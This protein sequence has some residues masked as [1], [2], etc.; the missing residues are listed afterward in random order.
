VKY[1]NPRL[2][3]CSSMVAGA[4]FDGPSYAE[5]FSA[6]C[7]RCGASKWERTKRGEPYGWRC[8]Y[9]GSAKAPSA[10]IAAI[11]EHLLGFR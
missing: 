11:E 9:C 6:G 5:D 1:E 7:A 8:A 4:Y 3:M 2:Y 10:A